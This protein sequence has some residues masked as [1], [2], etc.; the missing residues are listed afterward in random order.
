MMIVQRVNLLHSYSQDAVVDYLEE[1][2][3]NSLQ[4][5]LPFVTSLLEEGSA[6]RGFET[7][8]KSIDNRF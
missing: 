2:S 8:R 1:G 4:G 3:W 7:F 5:S 6:G